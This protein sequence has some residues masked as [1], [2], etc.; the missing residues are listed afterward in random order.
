MTTPDEILPEQ[1]ARAANRRAWNELSARYQADHGA[2]DRDIYY[3]PWA[4]PD[5]DLQL[6]GD[7]QGLRILDVG[8]GGGQNCIALAR[9]KAIVT[10]LDISDAQL[11]AAANHAAGA[12]VAATYV[13]GTAEDL[14]GFAA[15][16][17]DLIL[18]V[19]TMHYVPDALRAL[20]EF[21]RVLTPAGR[22]VISLDHPLRDC[23]FNL[24]E[25]SQEIYPVRGY[26]DEQ[27]MRWR[28]PD[29]R[30]WLTS[31]HR[32]IADW[33]ALFSQ[34]GFVLHRLLEPTVPADLLDAWWPVDDA[35]SS[36]R[37]LPHG[38]IFVAGKE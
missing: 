20:V 30:V 24:E 37:H 6:L 4:A 16:C 9:R 17:F 38:V 11:E 22:L 7:V 14:S 19:Q 1:R 15:H 8:C 12:G 28:W 3:G 27:P 31:Y 35:M 26:F 34:S 29:S 10:G 5:A 13:H 18:S 32:T 23:F 21:H 36:M 25:Q 2:G 33:V